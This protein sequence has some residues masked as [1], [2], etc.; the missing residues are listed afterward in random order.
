MHGGTGCDGLACLA[1]TPNTDVGRVMGPMYNAGSYHCTAGEWDE[2]KSPRVEW[3]WLF[4]C[5]WSVILS[6]VQ[7]YF[8]YHGSVSDYRLEKYIYIYIRFDCVLKQI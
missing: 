6:Q 5:E 2:A 3:R 8:I 4:I 7:R 1:D